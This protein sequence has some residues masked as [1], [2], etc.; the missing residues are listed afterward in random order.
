MA[1]LALIAGVALWWGA[2]LWKR[3]APES[4][5]RF[6]DPGKGIV[7][8]LLVLAIVLMTLGYRGAEGAFFWG[9]SPA[10]V[11]INNLLM[12]LAFYLFASSG[13]KTRITRVVKNPQLTAF[14]IWAASHLL[15]NGD[16]PSFVLFGGLLAWA[17]VEVIVLKRAGVPWEPPHP[18][19]IKKEVTAI[20]AAIVATIVVMLIHY[21]LGVVP[22]G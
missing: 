1:W 3:V 10:L 17:V 15:V 8:G 5:A 13:P 18:A 7:T 19:P 20:V 22:W 4:R 6:G 21:W 9:R 11:G 16:V 12:L 2:H 14:K